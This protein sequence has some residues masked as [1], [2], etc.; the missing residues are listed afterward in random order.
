MNSA[1]G[2]QIKLVWIAAGA[3]ALMLA[4]SC[5]NNAVSLQQDD[6]QAYGDTGKDASA[7][8]VSTKMSVTA[9]VA[10]AL[11]ST[12]VTFTCSGTTLAQA[13]LFFTDGTSVSKSFSSVKSGTVSANKTN[14][15]YCRAKLGSGDYWYF[16]KSGDYW[17]FDRSGTW[18]P[19]STTATARSTSSWGG[20]SASAG[21]AE[22][23]VSTLILTTSDDLVSVTFEDGEVTATS[24]SGLVSINACYRNGGYDK[25]DLDGDADSGD[26]SAE[27]CYCYV[28]VTA[29]GGWWFFDAEGTHLP[30][31]L[32]TQYSGEE[33]DRRGNGGGS[34]HRR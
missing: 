31:G 11:T 10:K 21:E 1:I 24:T 15:W 17:Y 30:A 2:R 8:R 28:L 7:F 4:A 6:Q 20:D 16:D 18:K 27:D 22:L 26:V 3:L 13:T 12:S 25:L 5:S 32:F 29:D 34:R 33:N 14:L 9:K 23:T 19:S